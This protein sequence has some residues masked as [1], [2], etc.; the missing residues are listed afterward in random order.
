MSWKRTRKKIGYL[1][2]VWAA[3]GEYFSPCGFFCCFV[4]F[5]L[6]LGVLRKKFEKKEKLKQGTFPFG[7]NEKESSSVSFCWI[8]F[9]LVFTSAKQAADFYVII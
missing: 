7:T 1:V 5:L 9:F 2:V 4:S 8:H 6:F 3:L